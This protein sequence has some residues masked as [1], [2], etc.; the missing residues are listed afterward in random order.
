MKKE[1]E[2]KE[3]EVVLRAI[4]T[5]PT[6]G[7]VLYVAAALLPSGEISPYEQGYK[8]GILAMVVSL[9]GYPNTDPATVERVLRNLP[10]R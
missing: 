2:L 6:G 8:I 4:S 7:D 10:P 9:L 5:Q 3:W 1:Q